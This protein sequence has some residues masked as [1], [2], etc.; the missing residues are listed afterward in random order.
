MS[1]KKSRL[2]HELIPEHSK[3]SE[4]E[5]KI[6]LNTYN[7]TIKEIPKI[8]ISDP[9]ITHLNV[10]EGDIIKIKRKSRTAGEVIYFRGVVND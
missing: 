9:A 7:I 6:L 3:L 8:L 1:A 2:V 10:K 4:K 5:A